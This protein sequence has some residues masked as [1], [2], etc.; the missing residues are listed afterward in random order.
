MPVLSAD[1]AR[2]LLDSID[3]S[4]LTG[5][6]DRTIIAVMVYSIARVGAVCAMNVEDYYGN[7]RAARG[8]DR[9]STSRSRRSDR[10]IT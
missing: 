3:A 1:Q 9:G 2:K 4:R 6:R 5:Q 8:S 7:D 10:E